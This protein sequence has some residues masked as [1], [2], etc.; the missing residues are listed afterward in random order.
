MEFEDLI[1]MVR[2]SYVDQFSEFVDTQTKA[3]GPKGAA[4]V[5]LVLPDDSGLYRN[6]YCADY[7]RADEGDVIE[8][9]PEE[10]VTFDP[11]DVS[12]NDMNMHIER[13]LWNDV[14]IATERAVDSLELAEW[15]ETWFDPDDTSFDPDTRFSGNI[16]SLSLDE[17]GVHVDLGTAPVEALVDLLIVF[18]ASGHSQIK[19][20]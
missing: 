5:K 6:L 12:L 19:V 15:F 4:E 3:T 14:T 7:S 17:T 11:V 2:D 8:L 13:L 10:E 1:E 18:E 20:T 9:L 16:H